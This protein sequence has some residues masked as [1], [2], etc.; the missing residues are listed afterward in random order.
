MAIGVEAHAEGA[1]EVHDTHTANISTHA[2][3]RGGPGR[4]LGELHAVADD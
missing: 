2:D 1:A 4:M 3:G